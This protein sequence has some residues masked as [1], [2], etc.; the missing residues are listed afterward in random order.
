M[1]KRVF[2]DRA[3]VTCFS[4]FVPTGPKNKWCSLICRLR[5]RIDMSGGPHCCWP[6]LAST[7][8]NGYGEIN[9]DH[10]IFFAHRIALSVLG[11]ID[12]SDSDVVR[13]ACD[14]PICCNPDH[15]LLGSQGD[16]VQDMVQRGRQQD[17][18]KVVRG[19]ASG[20]AKITAEKAMEIFLTTGGG[21]RAIAERLGVT[22]HI[23]RRIKTGQS[24]NDVTGMPV[25]HPPSKRRLLASRLYRQAEQESARV[26]HQEG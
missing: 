25:N 4:I 26:R 10:K 24:W 23:V 13:H 14:N 12:V 15:L 6:W 5:D 18:T 11:R 1:G 22:Y 7:D 20:Q 3:C 8:K 19:E 2:R 21:H 16:N 17:Y 9:I